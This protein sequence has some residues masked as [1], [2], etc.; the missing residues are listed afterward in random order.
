MRIGIITSPF[1]P[2]P[3]NA[4]GAIERRW[5]Y[6]GVCMNAKGH[7]VTFYSKKDKCYNL[8]DSV[9]IT[10]INGYVRTKSVYGDIVKD[11]VFTLKSLFRLRQC[12]ILVQNTFWAPI[13]SPLVW[14]KY[15][16]AVY[17]V[18]RMPKGQ[19]RFYKA[20]DQ[21]SCV[22]EAV[23][24]ALETE[25]GHSSKIVTVC[26][27][28]N[29]E[30]YK[31]S[32]KDIETDSVAIV[33][34]GR[35]HKEKGLDLL[36]RATQILSLDY[37]IRL[38]LIGPYETGKGGSGIEYV[39]MLKTLCPDV[40]ISFP[41][42]INDPQT[43]NEELSKCDIYCYPSIAD[44]GET[45]GVSPLE[46]M[47]TGRPIVVSGL[48][49]FKDFIEDGKN[50]LVFDHHADNAVE[51]LAGQIKKLIDSSELRYELGMAAYRKA[52]EFS[53]ENITERYLRNFEH[54]LCSKH[55]KS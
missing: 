4:L 41:G 10:Q 21:F 1:G 30:Y 22:S 5:Y 31:Y 47:G 35:I 3:P 15:K 24:E 16:K 38:N 2:L 52:Q 39:N 11:F 8:A 20:I 9:Q 26:N 23:K 25:I 45:F 44:Q 33:Y 46:A 13:L 19:F 54:L 53:V 34:H 37:K 49:C 7:E 51:Q 43:L 36:C 18:A 42:G 48:A 14:W 55:M 50:G 32:R 40:E 6:V 27:P 29:L 12:D 17:N 28:L